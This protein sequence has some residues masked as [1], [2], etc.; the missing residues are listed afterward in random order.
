[1]NSC[2]ILLHMAWAINTGRLKMGFRTDVD[3][4]L[5][6]AVPQEHRTAADQFGKGKSLSTLALKGVALLS[7][8]PDGDLSSRDEASES[9]HTANAHGF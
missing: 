2:M 7:V 5:S 6:E 8:S 3:A 1:M 4:N 9:M